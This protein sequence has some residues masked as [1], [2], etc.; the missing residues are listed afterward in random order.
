MSKAQID[1]RRHQLPH[2]G[3]MQTSMSQELV[4]KVPK[5]ALRF[6]DQHAF[7]DHGRGHS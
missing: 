5:V 1:G 2:P 3:A 4:G 7:R 6:D